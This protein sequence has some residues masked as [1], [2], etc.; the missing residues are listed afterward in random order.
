[1][2]PKVVIVDYGLGNVVSVYR[3]FDHIGAEPVLSADPDM[4]ARA[5]RLVLPGVGAFGDGM[6]QLAERGLDDAVRQFAKSGKPVLGICL[7]MQMMLDVGEEFGVHA[8]LGLIPGKVV[9]IPYHAPDGKT[10]K[11]PHVGWSEI[12]PAQDT[13]FNHAIF[14]DT[15]A[16]SALYFVH[17]FMAAPADPAHTL[18]VVDYDGIAIT[19]AVGRDNVV[20][21]QFHPEKSGPAGLK[22]LRRFIR[23]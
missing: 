21:M 1:M 22:I 10:V 12:V 18:A 3:A 4:V 11:V 17:S 2:N 19:A 5:D 13:G 14:A 23:I 9:A 8:G 16:G 15:A 7:G 6:A 20:G